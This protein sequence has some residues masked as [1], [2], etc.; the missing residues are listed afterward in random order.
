M[1]SNE[2][3]LHHHC[4]LSRK[5]STREWVPVPVVF[6]HIRST[7][8]SPS[9]SLPISSFLSFSKNPLTRC[10]VFGPKLWILYSVYKDFSWIFN[11]GQGICKGNSNYYQQTYC[12]MASLYFIFLVFSLNGLKTFS[13]WFLKWKSVLWFWDRS[14]FSWHSL[15]N[16][17][18]GLYVIWKRSLLYW[19]LSHKSVMNFLFRKVVLYNVSLFCFICKSELL[20]EEPICQNSLLYPFFGPVLGP[21]RQRAWISLYCSG[22]VKGTFVIN[23]PNNNIEWIMEKLRGNYTCSQRQTVTPIKSMGCRTS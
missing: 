17:I 7:T 2:M 15:W 1:I 3:R 19:S 13:L 6:S 8:D 21:V 10:I 22:R 20:G 4:N 5:I 16:S 23:K 18:C 9:L 12:K 11:D 14:L